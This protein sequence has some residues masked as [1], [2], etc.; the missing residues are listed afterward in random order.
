MRY[1]V[2]NIA[3]AAFAGV[4]AVIL[5]YFMLLDKPPLIGGVVVEQVDYFPKAYEVVLKHEGGYTNDPVDKGGATSFGISLSFLKDQN[6][7]IDQDGDVDIDDVKAIRNNHAKNIYRTFF[8]DKNRYNEIKN[9][10]VAIKLFDTAV[11]VGANR[12][13]KILRNTLNE[14]IVGNLEVN[15]TMDDQIMDMIN[16]I[17]PNMLLNEFRKQQADFYQSLV[18]KTPAYKKYRAG[19]LSRAKS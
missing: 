7:D 13:H 12:C 4:P 19:W 11:N 9:K 10:S 17:D 16:I 15:G 2:R 8:W 18:T 1:K 5:G 14:I 6:L 3:L